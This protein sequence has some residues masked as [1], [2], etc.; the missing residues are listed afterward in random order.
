MKLLLIFCRAKEW[1][2]REGE[3][4]T[5][6]SDRSNVLSGTPCNRVIYPGC[7][8]LFWPIAFPTTIHTE[9]GSLV[10]VSS[11]RA[12]V[13]CEFNSF[14]IN[15]YAPS[16]EKRRRRYKR[17]RP[18]CCRCESTYKFTSRSERLA[19]EAGWFQVTHPW[20]HTIPDS[21]YASHDITC[22][23]S[24]C[25]NWETPGERQWPSTLARK[26]WRK[27]RR[28]NCLHLIL[29]ACVFASSRGL[30][31]QS[32]DLNTIGRPVGEKSAPQSQQ[33]KF[34]NAF[35]GHIIWENPRPGEE[36]TGNRF[37]VATESRL[38]RLYNLARLRLK[39]PALARINDSLPSNF[40]QC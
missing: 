13:S 32:N 4:S 20:F 3:Q 9:Q 24:L 27:G 22:N 2:G 39:N 34:Q 12:R 1:E 37:A 19:N 18:F 15:R 25:E 40:L 29:Y 14:N 7:F 5:S 11:A 28:A 10:S 8:S 38:F 33:K 26:L 36:C 17:K 21:L 30:I 16:L 31:L 35:W 23:K 6:F